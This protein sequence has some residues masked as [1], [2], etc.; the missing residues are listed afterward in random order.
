MAD[1]RASWGAACCAPTQ[2]GCRAVGA[3]RIAGSYAL[4]THSGAPPGVFP[5]SGEVVQNEWLAEFPETG[6]RKPLEIL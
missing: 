3:S 6:M 4:D 2:T 1:A 5:K